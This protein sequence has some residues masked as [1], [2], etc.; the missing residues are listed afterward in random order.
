MSVHDCLV[1]AL[2]ALA[3]GK[4]E[5]RQVH[6]LGEHQSKTSHRFHRCAQIRRV[7]HPAIPTQPLNYLPT[8]A[9]EPYAA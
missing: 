4:A 6:P 7:W 8:E 1:G 9:T 5:R 3:S 2:L